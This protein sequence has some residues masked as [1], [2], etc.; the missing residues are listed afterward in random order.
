MA[1]RMRDFA[2]E[3]HFSK[4]E[5]TA[6]Y[7]LAGSDAET[8]PISE[9]L[10]MAAPGDRK[11]FE[12]LEL[13]YTETFGS[14]ALRSAI[15]DTYDAI[16]EDRVLCLAGAQEGIYIASQVL[17]EPGDHAIVIT[18]NYQ[19]AETVPL[20]ICEVS[21][22]P[23][24]Q[25]AG[26]AFDPARI[27]DALKPNTRLV[28]INFPNNPTGVIPPRAAIDELVDMCRE[29]GIWIFSDEVYW[30]IERDPA[31]RL[32]QLADIY[33]KAV[34]LN[35]MSKAYGLPGLRI[36]WFACQDRDTLVRFERFKHYLSICC[37][38]PS[39]ALATIALKAREQ[40]VDRNRMLV[41]QNAALV[42]EF[43]GQYP[44]LFEFHE[45]DGGCVCF[46]RYKGADGVESF[47]SR[48]VEDSGVLL[49]P[50]SV[51]RSEIA[52]VPQNY[53]RIGLGRKL[54][55]TALD[56]FGAWLEN[57]YR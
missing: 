56:A 11:A 25:D 13:G 18:P 49:L 35:V 24:D 26:W 34:S 27:R 47:T 48:L 52:D 39:E 42:G 37:A 7:N 50:S 1:Q 22:V 3:V 45:P 21:G 38:A 19:S 28:S 6:R 5:F 44:D 55:P 17:L 32:P 31:L 2:L 54:V 46:T 23:L 15:A 36:G 8:L 20:S 14:P 53:F 12:K 57:N 9:L 33:E 10:E 30:L 29:R 4:W 43:L 41:R 40:I 51:Y 16:G